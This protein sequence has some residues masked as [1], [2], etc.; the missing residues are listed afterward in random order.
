L[1][2]GNATMIEDQNI[3]S[4]SVEE[5]VDLEKKVDDLTSI[6]ARQTQMLDAL[7]DLPEVVKRLQESQMS[8]SD[9]EDGDD[10]SELFGNLETQSPPNSN[11]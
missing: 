4:Q 8:E 11:N 5:P 2:S 6:I 10:E 3:E 7:K 1:Y 9:V